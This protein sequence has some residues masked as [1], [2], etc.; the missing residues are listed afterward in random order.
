MKG[1]V[2]AGG[3][4]SRLRPLTHTHAKQLIPVANKPILFYGLEALAQAN[5]TEVGIVVGETWRDIQKAVGRGEKWGLEIEYIY[6]EKPLG[7]AHAVYT[8]RTF[9]GQSSFLLYLGDNILLEPLQPYI[10]KFMHNE[11]ASLILL[12]PVENPRNFGVAELNSQNRVCRLIEKPLTPPSN[13][14]LIGVYCFSSHVL[15]VIPQ[16]SPSWR[17]EYEITHAIQALI[18]AGQEVYPALV[19]SWWKDTG[20]KEDLLEANTMLLDLMT[21]HRSG[22]VVASRIEGSVTIEE[23]ARIVESSIQGPAII[24][25]RAII[26]SSTIGPYT[27]IGS[28]AKLY[29]TI[30]AG[31]IIMAM[32]HIHCPGIRL[33]NSL[34]GEEVD[35]LSR[36]GSTG[37]LELMLGDCSQVHLA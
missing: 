32:A 17:G 35:V 10:E 31:S 37:T 30:V 12:Q 26:Q 19:H 8:A 14:A 5:I 4:G 22:E 36:A 13:L 20:R 27:S 1:L 9:L 2:L 6:Q 11:Y 24:G 16:L 28:E 33:Q 21:P 18:N 34:L 3:R 29:N 23:G 25:K 15:E 7:L